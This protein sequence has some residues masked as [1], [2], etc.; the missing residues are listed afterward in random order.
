MCDSTRVV[1]V[2]PGDVLLLGNVGHIVDPVA[3]ANA[4]KGLADVG[5]ARTLVF[6]EDID[7][8]AVD[9]AHFRRIETPVACPECRAGKCQ[10]CCGETLDERDEIS[11]CPCKEA[12]HAEG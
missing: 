5:I 11:P 3:C 12:G 7:L 10:N 9:A 6:A 1:L 2:K 4:L 8:A